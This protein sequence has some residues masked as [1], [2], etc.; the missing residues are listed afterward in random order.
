MSTFA[1]K[2]HTD[3]ADPDRP[4]VGTKFDYNDQTVVIKEVGWVL[5]SAL[6]KEIMDNIQP[7]V[8]MDPKGHD[9]CLVKG[10]ATRPG[11]QWLVWGDYHE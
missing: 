9:V 2:F 4:V 8:I 7:S 10:H 1:S 3:D 5:T 6:V 11:V